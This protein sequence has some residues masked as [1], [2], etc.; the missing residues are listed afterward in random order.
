MDV[1]EAPTSIQLS[2]N[3]V[4]EN[5]AVGTLVGNITVLDP[6]NEG[7]YAGTQKASCHMIT[8][9]AGVFEINKNLQLVVKKGALNFE[10]KARCVALSTGHVILVD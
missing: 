2:K 10:E 4:D 1:N 8:D 5:S 3:T 7:K 6:D 9:T